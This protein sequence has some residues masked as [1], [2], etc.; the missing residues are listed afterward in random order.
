[1]ITKL[2]R[3]RSLLRRFL[4][5]T[6]ATLAKS[7]TPSM[8][9]AKLRAP[10]STRTPFRRFVTKSLIKTSNF[11]LLTSNSANR[12]RARTSLAHS[13]R[14]RSPLTSLALHILRWATMAA[15]APVIT[16]V[17]WAP[18]QYC[19]GIAPIGRFRQC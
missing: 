9:K 17:A 18:K 5:R 15:T 12:H 16:A 3:L 7:L 2:A 19:L 6:T 13:V 1:M 8:L 4:L 14:S 10:S 11:R